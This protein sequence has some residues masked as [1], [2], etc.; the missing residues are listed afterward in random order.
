MNVRRYGYT[1]ESRRCPCEVG[2][3]AHEMHWRPKNRVALHAPGCRHSELWRT[4]VVLAAQRPK[5]AP[6][7]L[8]LLA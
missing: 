2:T 5:R 8:L 1:G 4:A 7:R 6:R 3:D